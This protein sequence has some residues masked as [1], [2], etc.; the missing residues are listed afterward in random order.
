M[1]QRVATNDV[2]RPLVGM[3]GFF[4]QHLDA[5]IQVGRVRAVK[6]LCEARAAVTSLDG[7]MANAFRQLG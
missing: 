5:A 4:L 7:P 1:N 2:R 3:S 6:E